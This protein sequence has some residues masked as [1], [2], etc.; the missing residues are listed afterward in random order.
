MAIETPGAAPGQA[1]RLWIEGMLAGAATRRSSSV[2]STKRTTG[3]RWAGGT[4]R[5]HNP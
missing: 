2:S 4:A 1:N 3:L 5:T